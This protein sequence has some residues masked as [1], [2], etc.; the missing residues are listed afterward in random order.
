[1]KD[2]EEPGLEVILVR[3]QQGPIVTP[4]LFVFQKLLQFHILGIRIITEN[5]KKRRHTWISKVRKGI[6]VAPQISRRESEV[7]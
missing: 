7:Q 3:K 6:E 1:M 5:K 2:P 4:E